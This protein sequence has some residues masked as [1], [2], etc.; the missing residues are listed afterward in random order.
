MLRNEL[1]DRYV[2]HWWIDSDPERQLPGF[3]TISNEH[4]LTIIGSLVGSSLDGSRTQVIHG[5]ANGRQ[6]TLIEV[7]TR[8]DNPALSSNATSTYYCPVVLVG[9]IDLTGHAL[10]FDRIDVTFERMG[11]FAARSGLAESDG[12]AG[13]SELSHASVPVLTASDSLGRRYTLEG[14]LW[15]DHNQR[16]VQWNEDEILT[17]DLPSPLIVRDLL[18]S[19]VGSLQNLLHLC[20]GYPT[21]ILDL[22]VSSSASPQTPSTSWMQVIL[23]AGTPDPDR[24]RQVQGHEYLMTLKDVPFADIIPRWMDLSHILGISIDILFGLDGPHSGFVSTRLL[25]AAAAAEGMHRRLNPQRETPD[26]KHADRVARLLNL[27]LDRKDKSWLDRKLKYSH[28]LDFSTRLHELCREAGTAFLPYSGN[29]RK[30]AT[31]I[32]RLRNMVAHS[33]DNVERRPAALHRLGTTLGLLLRIVLLQRLGLDADRLAQRLS[34]HMQ[35]SYLKAAL[36]ADV[37]E[38]F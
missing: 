19:P 25:N 24:D 33:L 7:S 4:E 15:S 23:Y 26:E 20:S 36:Q 12:G 1:P 22:Q 6:I 34:V 31:V 18:Q 37:P 21:R 2:G 38:I 13:S 8:F 9:N 14:V 29:Q 5:R 3:L 10:E 30:W 17:I 28:R 11:V 27:I 35:W 32:V 16:S